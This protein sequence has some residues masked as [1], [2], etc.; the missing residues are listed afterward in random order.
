MM[1]EASRLSAQSGA[2]GS[3]GRHLFYK[4]TLAARAGAHGGSAPASAEHRHLQ[5]RGTEPRFVRRSVN[6]AK[7]AKQDSLASG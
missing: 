1:T 2:V 5:A 6:E 7:Q 3:E 4:L